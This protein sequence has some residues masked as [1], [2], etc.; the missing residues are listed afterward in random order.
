L[1]VRTEPERFDRVLEHPTYTSAPVEP[2]SVPLMGIAEVTPG[3]IIATGL[4]LLISVLML[5]RDPFK[6]ANQIVLGLLLGVVGWMVYMSFKKANAVRDAPVERVIGVIVGEQQD[7]RLRFGDARGSQRRYI[8]VQTRDGHKRV[9][10]AP[11][12]VTARFAVDDIGIVYVKADVL[13]DFV[14]VDV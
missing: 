13:V 4:S 5:L 10:F 6:T 3:G 8:Q 9:Y 12:H 11:K 7:T 2:V 1:I 14:R